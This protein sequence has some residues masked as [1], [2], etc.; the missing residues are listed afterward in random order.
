[1]VYA[2]IFTVYTQPVKEPSMLGSVWVA[3]SAWRCEVPVVCSDTSEQL[4]YLGMPGLTPQQVHLWLP[5][6]TCHPSSIGPLFVKS[7][8]N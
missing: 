2:Y 7:P 5:R 1:M 4:S 8:V 6:W 3:P